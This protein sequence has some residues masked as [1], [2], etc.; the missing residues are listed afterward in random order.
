MA[1]N[2]PPE[3]AC[4]FTVQSCGVLGKGPI[5]AACHFVTPAL[6][7]GDAPQHMAVAESGLDTL[8]LVWQRPSRPNGT[9]TKYR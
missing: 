3:T 6:R 9:I 7:P 1:S 5:S 4:F 2:L 8:T